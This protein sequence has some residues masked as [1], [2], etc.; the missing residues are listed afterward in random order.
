MCSRKLRA[1]L[2]SHPTAT[3]AIQ[4]QAKKKQQRS[5]FGPDRRH[6]SVASSRQVTHRGNKG[7]AGR[8]SVRACVVC[9]TPVSVARLMRTH[10]TPNKHP[11]SSWRLRCMP[12]VPPVFMALFERCSAAVGGSTKKRVFLTRLLQLYGRHGRLSAREGR[13]HMEPRQ[14]FWDA[15]SRRTGMGKPQSPSSCWRSCCKRGH[16]DTGRVAYTGRFSYALTTAHA[17]C[18]CV[19]AW[20]LCVLCD[21]S[22]C[23]HKINTSGLASHT[24]DTCYRDAPQ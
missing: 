21:A 6:C 2:T 5:V 20:T 18:N 19:T 3:R 15:P 9:E 13:Q 22:A 7:T 24:N 14:I 12:H 10:G 23:L 11:P 4:K 16:A 1:V 17:L 8:E